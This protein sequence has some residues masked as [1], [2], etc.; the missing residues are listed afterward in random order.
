MGGA[1][2]RFF[3]GVLVRFFF[4][5]ALVRARPCWTFWRPPVVCGV[6]MVVWGP[7]R[8]WLHGLPRVFGADVRSLGQVLL[9]G[10]DVKFRGDCVGEAGLCGEV[11]TPARRRY[12]DHPRP[13]QWWRPILLGVVPHILPSVSLLALVASLDLCQSE[14]TLCSA[15]GAAAAAAAWARFAIRSVP[16]EAEVEMEDGSAGPTTDSPDDALFPQETA[17]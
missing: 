14:T 11:P 13:W 15:M 9:D 10:R 1:V 6:G 16:A 2:V 17:C 7:Q 5:R 12:R 8:W 3:W 4:W